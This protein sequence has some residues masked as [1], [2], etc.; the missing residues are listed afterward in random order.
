MQRRGERGVF[1]GGRPGGIACFASERAPTRK[2]ELA[3]KHDVGLS[4]EG[5]FA[6]NAIK[7]LLGEG[8]L[9]RDWIFRCGRSWLFFRG[10]HC[11]ASVFDGVAKFAGGC[12]EDVITIAIEYRDLITVR[13]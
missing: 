8:S 7:L 3:Q 5:G 10:K 12:A 9:H 4:R 1:G 2:D 11:L 6:A 13:Q